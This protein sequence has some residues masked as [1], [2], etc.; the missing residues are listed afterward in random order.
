MADGGTLDPAFIDSL[1]GPDAFFDCTL[2]ARDGYRPFVP[3]DDAAYRAY[4]LHF[5][6]LRQDGRPF[7]VQ[8]G[9]H[10]DPTPWHYDVLPLING[11]LLGE[12]EL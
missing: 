7:R 8:F 6:R 12:E 1:P 4:R 3:R 10:L 9:D 2:F 11:K 5:Y